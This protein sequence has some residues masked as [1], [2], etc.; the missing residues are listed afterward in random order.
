VPGPPAWLGWQPSPARAKTREAALQAARR[1][2]PQATDAQIVPTEV[3]IS[4][5]YACEPRPYAY[6]NA[7]QATLHGKGAGRYNGYPR[8]PR[9]AAGPASPP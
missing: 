5:L 2:D 6:V 1:L 9:E 7:V 3:A 4:V 8:P